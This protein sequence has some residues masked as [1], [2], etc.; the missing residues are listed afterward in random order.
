MGYM[1]LADKIK[2][3]SQEST[4]NLSQLAKRAGLKVGTVQA[5]LARDSDPSASMVLQF[6]RGAGVDVEWLI[7]PKM[8]L[9]DLPAR[10]HW[11]REPIAVRPGKQRM[12]KTEAESIFDPGD[13]SESRVSQPGTRRRNRGA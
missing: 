8:G 2:W 9:E 3:I 10:P 6:A 13:E 11:L 7:D 1:M 5:W 4:W 12:L